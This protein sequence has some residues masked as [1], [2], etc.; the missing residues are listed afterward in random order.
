M[1]GTVWCMGC[2]PQ[3]HWTIKPLIGTYTYMKSFKKLQ[4]R[5]AGELSD[6]IN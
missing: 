6:L 5:A 4:W 2:L 3:Y 1:K